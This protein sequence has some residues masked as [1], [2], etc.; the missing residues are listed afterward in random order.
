M[1]QRVIVCQE[2]VHLDRAATKPPLSS[3]KAMQEE[4]LSLKH[5][6]PEQ[7][8]WPKYLLSWAFPMLFHAFHLPP[9]TAILLVLNLP[10]PMRQVSVL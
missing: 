5:L 10:T 6:P 3:A 9:L 8:L 7:L 1:A 2:K 4:H